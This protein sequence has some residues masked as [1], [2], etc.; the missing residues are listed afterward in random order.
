MAPLLLRRIRRLIVTGISICLGLLLITTTFASNAVAKG[1]T[2][3]GDYLEDTISVAQTL[4]ETISIPKES[5]GRTKSEQ[6]A[7][8]LITDYIS[9]YRN[10]P[11]INETI[12]YTTMQTALNALAGHYNNSKRPLSEDLKNRLDSE[13]SKA[14]E[15]VKQDTQENL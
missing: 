12:S 7:V 2:L 14:T 5:K 8:G 11:Q 13:L 6:E 3:S 9:R 4:R 15:L 10:R 1:S